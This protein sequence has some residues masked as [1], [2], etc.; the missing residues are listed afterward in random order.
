[1]QGNKENLNKFE[2]VKYL[3][4]YLEPRRNKPKL[5]DIKI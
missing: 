3:R 4:L 1:M 2:N 5:N